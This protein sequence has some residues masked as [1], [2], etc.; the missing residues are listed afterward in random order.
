MKDNRQSFEQTLL[1][2]W[3][4]VYR[5]SQLTLWL[6]LSLKEGPK[7]VAQI[8]S[9]IGDATNGLVASDEQ[10]IYRALRRYHKVELVGYKEV[11]GSS[12]PARKEY[13]LTDVGLRVL[14]SFVKRNIIDTLFRPDI[15]VLIYKD[16]TK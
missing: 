1:Q 9:F 15:Q 5:K 11:P 14:N 16:K 3:E 13:Y 7:H 8:K 2:G 10:S 4:D 12:G 6:L